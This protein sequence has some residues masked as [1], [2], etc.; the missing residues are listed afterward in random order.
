MGIKQVVFRNLSNLPG[1]RTKRKIIVIESDDWGSIRMPSTTIFNEL[2]AS[3]D[4][5]GSD[6]LRYNKNDTLASSEDLSALYDTLFSFKDY[7]KNNPVFTAISVV[8]NPDF[9]KIES[10]DFT[11]Y[12][13]EPFTATLENY[14]Y[15]DAYDLWLEG[16]NNK[17]F[18][19]QFHGREH[20][21]VAVW[22]EAL[23]NN[24][25]QTM[26]AFSKG[27]WG[28]NN[29]NQFNI[30]Y[31]AAFDLS[32]PKEVAYHHDI[33]VDGLRIF[34]DLFGYKASYFVPPNGSFNNQLEETAA[35]AGIR[36]MSAAKLQHEALGKGKTRK[37]F[38]YLGQKNKYQQTYITRNAFFEPSQ[39]GKDW[40]NSCL[41]DI[42]IA[43]KWNKPAIISTHRVNYIGVLNEKNRTNG[44]NQ[45]N[46]LLS[47]ILKKWPEVEFMT[48][49]ELGDLIS[50]R[51]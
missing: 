9:Y 4:L 19:P 34:E 42:E 40:V 37:V 22:M 15:A 11:N 46:E 36:Y 10:S 21:N 23:K 45:L 18:I 30:M 48:S 43:F 13:Y 12:Y 16:I 29:S 28:Y 51:R 24:D 7:N 33:I 50:K 20:L 5:K 26:L 25:A 1:W 35:E 6:S 2:T 44:L 38:H 27:L 31:Q 17:L 14:G 39:D 47:I 8:A 41:S 32:N 3:M 49:V